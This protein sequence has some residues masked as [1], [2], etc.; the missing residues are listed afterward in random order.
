MRK[1]HITLLTM[2]LINAFLVCG[3]ENEVTTYKLKSR[4]KS[5]CFHEDK[6]GDWYSTGERVSMAGACNSQGKEI[7][8]PI[9]YNVSKRTGDCKRLPVYYLVE[10]KMQ[11]LGVYD[12]LGTMVIP[13]EYTYIGEYNKDNLLILGKNGTPALGFGIGYTSHAKYGIYDLEKKNFK[14]PCIYSYIESGLYSSSPRFNEGGDMIADLSFGEKCTGGK[15][16][17]LNKEGDILIPAQYE[18]ALPFRD[19]VA[20]VVKDGIASLLVE[21]EKGTQLQLLNGEMT[22]VVD[23]G[24]PQTN[25][26]NEET[27]AFIIANENYANALR[28]DFSC[29]DGKVFSEYCKKTFGLPEHNIRYY[30]DATYGNILKAIQGAKDIIEAYDGDVQ[31]IF[32]YAGLG[33]VDDKTQEGYLLPVDVSL[34]SLATTGYSVRKLVHELSEIKTKMSLILLDTSFSGTDRSG[35]RLEV[36]RG[37]QITAKKIIPSNHTIVCTASTSKES[38]FCSKSLGHGLFTYALLD[39]LKNSKGECTLKELIDSAVSVVKK[40]SVKQF[41]IIQTPVVTVSSDFLSQWEHLK[42]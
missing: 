8:P 40:E 35:K 10:K 38:A 5:V 17:Y 14:I 33:A 13:C 21:P 9:Y 7:I 11:T 31:I 42:F 37:V 2:L 23:R 19:G 34:G 20:Q 25:K 18:S 22:N 41:S 12:T 36:N 39:K 26:K 16:G 15:W 6:S 30:E 27:F 28:G 32:Y 29:N 1:K 24:V 4:Y 3:Q